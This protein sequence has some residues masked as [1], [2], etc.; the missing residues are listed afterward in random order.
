MDRYDFFESFSG[1]DA[2]LLER[3]EQAGRPRGI[4]LWWAAAAACLVV[5]AAGAIAAPG[6][7]GNHS[8]DV[9]P[10]QTADVSEPGVNTAVPAASDPA[11]TEPAISLDVSPVEPPRL[12]FNQVTGRTG[13]FAAPVAGFAIF[14]EDLTDEEF[15]AAAPDVL[16]R[17]VDSAG[18]VQ[19]W[20]VT[21]FAGYYGWGELEGV[22]LEFLNPEWDGMVT[23]SLRKPDA[24]DHADVILEDPETVTGRMGSLE[25]TAYRWEDHGGVLMWAKFQIGGVAYTAY[26]N[27]GPEDA[28]QAE[29]DLHMVLSCYQG[30]ALS[31]SAPDLDGYHM[32]ETHVW[33]DNS[34]LTL[35]QA[36]EDE[37]FG[38]Y[39]PDSVPRGFSQDLIRRYKADDGD[40]LYGSWYSWSY[41]SL[42]WDV[43][44]LDDYAAARITSVED[45][46]NYDLSLYPIPRGESVPAELRSIVDN[47][48]FLIDELTLDT[49][50]ARAYKVNEA[51]DTDGWRM[52]FSVLYGGVVVKVYA[53]GVSPEWV[54]GQ[55]TK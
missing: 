4:K 44:Y 6:L 40:S 51:G 54:F 17:N 7:V 11:D 38:A 10:G 1:L 21:G 28:E 25:Y 29:R 53:K 46:E 19:Y 12:V 15:A 36:R 22:H 24:K 42:V 52:D 37:T 41:G 33:I 23:V 26:V 5:A 49:V 31:D 39:M 34:D 50:Y 3:S 55:L 8:A 27:T 9:E 30:R 32:K 2:A 16:P 43:S 20:E 45:R 18:G 35:A 14:G 47:P 13:P 48:V